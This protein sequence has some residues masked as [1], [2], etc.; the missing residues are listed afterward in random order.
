MVQ[1]NQ[2]PWGIRSSQLLTQ[3]S[4]LAGVKGPPI[5]F[6]LIAVQDEYVNRSPLDLIIAFVPGQSKIPQV[7]FDVP[8]LP[9]VITEGGEKPTTLN[10]LDVS[11]MLTQ[12]RTIPF[13]S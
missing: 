7:S 10:L 12:L 11:S 1:E 9:I 4:R 6:L 8:R 2:S 3:P 13:R 5:R